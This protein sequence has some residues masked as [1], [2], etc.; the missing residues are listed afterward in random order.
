MKKNII[1]NSGLWIRIG[2]Y[3][4]SVSLLLCCMLLM[5]VSCS[6]DD[7][8]SS[9]EKMAKYT[10]MFYG[11]GG[12]NLDANFIENFKQAHFY[13]ATD[14]VG[15]T[16]F[17][18]LS[19]HLQDSIDVGNMK[20]TFRYILPE[21]M[22]T[23]GLNVFDLPVEN[24]GDTLVELWRPETLAEFIKWSK[25]VRPAENYIL[26]LWNHGHGWLPQT[27]TIYTRAI[28]R[29]DAQDK[30]SLSLDATEKGVAMSGTHLAALYD[31]ACLMAMMENLCGYA[32][33]ADMFV[34][35]PELTPNLGGNYYEFLKALNTADGRKS[36]LFSALSNY[37][38]AIPEYWRRENPKYNYIDEEYIGDIEV[39]DLGR[40]EDLAKVFTETAKCL[41]KDYP[42][43][44][45]AINK[46]TRSSLSFYDG[47]PFI[48]FGDFVKNLKL[49]TRKPEF[50][51]L[52][53][54]F[55]EIYRSIS[56]IAISKHPKFVDR[57]VTLSVYSVTSEQYEENG[58]EEAY[59]HT[60]FDKLTHWS[61]WLKVNQQSLTWE[62]TSYT[63]R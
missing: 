21:K 14:K 29:D 43:D 1:L 42:T 37:C 6:N 7:D 26:V 54:R 49:E 55:N 32:T 10:V 47:D 34:G 61:D 52:A 40:I 2:N 59:P 46:A 9:S 17:F 38:D 24:V 30:K 25:S 56:H 39:I 41:V 44:S 31:D 36:S 27:D 20:G 8:D 23:L 12:G 63:K 13:G 22:D 16:Y 35:A 18:K 45:A 50:S 62:Y 19:K 5:F 53:D 57:D 58:C 4:L 3:S 11:C 51:V 48:D 15:M 28:I 60:E 33:I